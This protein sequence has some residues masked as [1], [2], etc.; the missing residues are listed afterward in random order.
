M[1]LPKIYDFIDNK[2]HPI[3]RYLF[4]LP[5][6]DFISFLESIKNRLGVS[7][8]LHGYEFIENDLIEFWDDS[9]GEEKCI[10]ISIIEFINLL[11]PLKQLYLSID[12]DNEESIVNLFQELENQYSI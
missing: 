4:V 11:E 3:I 1:I 8:E 6:N 2:Y 9:S 7:R 5:S 12:I 10:E